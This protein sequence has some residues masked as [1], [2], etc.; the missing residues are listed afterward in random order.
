[1]T[2]QKSQ[3]EH[4]MELAGTIHSFDEIEDPVLWQRQLRDAWGE[5]EAMHIALFKTIVET[6]TEEETNE[7]SK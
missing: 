2:E 3:S 7:D 5:R 4:L 6:K 1:M